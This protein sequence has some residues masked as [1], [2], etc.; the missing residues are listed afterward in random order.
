MSLHCALWLGACGGSLGDLPENAVG[1]SAN[2]FT[3]TSSTSADN[4]ELMR[5]STQYSASSTPSSP[6]YK[7]GPLDVLDITVFKVPELTRPVQVNENGTFNFP[8]VGEVSTTGRTPQE[9]ERLLTQKLGGRYL[10][11]PQVSI[12]VKE[13]NSQ[14]FTVEGAVKK[15]G[16]YPLRGQLTLLQGIAQAEGLDRDTASA[17]VIVFRQTPNGRAAARFDIDDIRGGKSQDPILQQGD[18]IVV[19]SSQSKVAFSYFVRAL[20]AASLFR[21]L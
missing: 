20:P 5:A 14:R 19:E 1:A 9:I 15:A 10:Q 2:S 8:L 17:N 7:I 6:G 16:V 21:L 3:R 13:F 12:F 4:A 11:S 18:T